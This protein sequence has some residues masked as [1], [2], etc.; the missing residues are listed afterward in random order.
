MYDREDVKLVEAVT[1]T[2]RKK[3]IMGLYESMSA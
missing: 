1:A 3:L 2:G